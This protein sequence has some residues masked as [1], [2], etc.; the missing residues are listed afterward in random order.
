MSNIKPFNTPTHPP[1]RGAPGN[2]HPTD[3]SKLRE[4]WQ[5]GHGAIDPYRKETDFQTADE[6]YASESD[7]S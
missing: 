6:H 2:E 7:G 3:P 1:P 4:I 5:T